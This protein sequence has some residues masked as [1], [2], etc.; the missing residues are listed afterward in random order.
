V[1]LEPTLLAGIV[2]AALFGMILFGIPIGAALML[3]GVGGIA[4]MLGWGP[5]FGMVSSQAASFFLSLDLA[6][7]PMFLLMG[8]L[9]SYARLSEEIY[10]IADS[11][12]GRLRGGHAYATIGGCAGFG[13]ICG[14]SLA[15]VA[16]MTRVALPEMMRRGYAPWLA[17][18]TIAGGSTLG[19]LIPP[20]VVMVLYAILTK[21]FVIDLFIAAIIPAI[22]AVLLHFVAIRTVLILRPDAAPPADNLVAAN[23]LGALRRGWRALGLILIVSVGIYGGFFTVTEAASVGLTLAFIFAWWTPGFRWRDIVPVLVDSAATTGMIY[24][25]IIGASVFGTFLSLT[26]LPGTAVDFVNSLELAPI[27]VIF[28]LLAMYLVLGSVFD[29][30]GAMVLTLPFVFPLVTGLGYDP[31]W[32]GII[33]VM[34]IEIG[35]LTPPIGMN[36]FVLNSMAS[37]TPLSTIFRGIVPFVTADLVRILILVLFPALATWLPGVLK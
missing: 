23:R 19:V 8:G 6:V 1:T 21:Q 27:M 29:T 4:V 22:I 26:N 33:N 30:I 3:A 12:L 5:A 14:S 25:M 9:A 24:L 7:I 17:T 10:T 20:S 34:I 35:L 16:V 11:W 18:G 31:I 15:T 37:Q 2:F 28:A 36:I 32:W 13:A